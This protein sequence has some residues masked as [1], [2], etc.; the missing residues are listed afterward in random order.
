MSNRKVVLFCVWYLLKLAGGG[1]F[2]NERGIKLFAEYLIV[3][4]A[5][6]RFLS[7]AE[8]ATTKKGVEEE[9]SE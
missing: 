5:H 9:G 3:N 1:R 7:L 2:A 6:Y 8:A 4:A